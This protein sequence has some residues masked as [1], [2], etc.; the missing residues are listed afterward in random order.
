[1]SAAVFYPLSRK[2]F[3][4]FF[5]TYLHLYTFLNLLLFIS[6]HIKY[7]IIYFVLFII[8]KFSYNEF[9]STTGHFNLYNTYILYHRQRVSRYY[10]IGKN[11]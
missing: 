10:I 2:R 1:V 6:F 5:Y 8:I 7:K 11:V 4:L 3:F 9:V